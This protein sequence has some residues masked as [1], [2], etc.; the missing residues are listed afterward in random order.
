MHIYGQ[1]KMELSINYVNIA[2]QTIFIMVKEI[3]LYQ[4]N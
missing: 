3:S 4:S 2:E 1:R